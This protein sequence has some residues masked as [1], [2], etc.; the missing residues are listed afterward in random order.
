MSSSSSKLA[1]ENWR[2]WW[3]LIVSV[4]HSILSFIIFGSNSF[5]FLPFFFLAQQQIISSLYFFSHVSAWRTLLG[6]LLNCYIFPF[7]I[8]SFWPIVTTLMKLLNYNVHTVWRGM[9][10]VPDTF[11]STVGIPQ[12]HSP[13]YKPTHRRGL[14]YY[15]CTVP[16]STT[17]DRKVLCTHSTR[18]R[19]WQPMHN[20]CN[21]PLGPAQVPF[22]WFLKKF[23]PSIMQVASEVVGVF[24]KRVRLHGTTPISLSSHFHCPSPKEV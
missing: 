19:A 2:Q 20:M 18:A 14:G 21:Q 8:S 12:P 23:P 1:R 24:T 5:Q 3:G 13:Y 4:L 11:C 16:G 6:F 22:F 17:S 7:E 15:V 9:N 10:P